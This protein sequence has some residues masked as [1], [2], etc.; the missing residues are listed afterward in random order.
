MCEI[1]SSGKRRGE[2]EDEE[3]PEEKAGEKS[4]DKELE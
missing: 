4:E 1:P 3:D 2:P